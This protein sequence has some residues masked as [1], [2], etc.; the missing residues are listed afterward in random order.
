VPLAVTLFWITACAALPLET[1]ADSTPAQVHTVFLEYREVSLLIN[2]RLSVI[3]QEV[4]FKKEPDLSGRS[5]FRGELSFGGR[6]AG[7]IPFIW[8]RSQGKLYLDLN[9]NRDLTDDGVFTDSSRRL[10][11][12]FT[13]VHLAFKTASGTR[14]VL[15]DL[16]LA[17]YGSRI[18]GAYAMLRSFWQGKISLQGQDWQV[19]VIENIASGPTP[20]YLLLRRWQ[21]RNEQLSLMDGSLDAFAFPTNLYF[22]NQAYKVTCAAEPEGTPPRLRLE[23]TEQPAKLGELRLT[24]AFLDRVILDPGDY[25]VVWDAP[26]PVVKAPVGRYPLHRV[27]LKHG[28]AEACRSPVSMLPIPGVT[29]SESQSTALQIGGPLTNSVTVSHRG[30]QLVFVYQLVGAD[31]VQYRLARQDRSEPPTFTVYQGNKRI[32]SGKFEFG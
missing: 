23:L 14:P 5:V 22:L 11:Q 6:V 24:G 10:F 31:R 21:N 28:N 26:G 15:V 32:A 12:V 27:R 3:R 8:D 9:L 16:N 17:G 2:L 1:A 20:G 19:G 13:N 4:S 18:P 29:V 25:T 30:R 7:A